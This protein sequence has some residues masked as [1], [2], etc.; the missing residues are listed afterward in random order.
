MQQFENFESQ[1]VFQLSAEKSL[2]SLV[3]A[4]SERELRPE[5]DGTWHRNC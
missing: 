5:A 3:Q 4:T 2:K 1:W